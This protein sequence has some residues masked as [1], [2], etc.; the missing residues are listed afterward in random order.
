M[1]HEL[2]ELLEGQDGRARMARGCLA[3]E[4]EVVSNKDREVPREGRLVNPDEVPALPG[5]REEAAPLSDRPC[6][7]S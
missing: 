1:T 2:V 4:I 6:A 7:D 5:S 3:K